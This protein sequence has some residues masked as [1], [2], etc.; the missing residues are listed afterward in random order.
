MVVLLR[1]HCVLYRGNYGFFRQ[2]LLPVNGIVQLDSMKGSSYSGLFPNLLRRQFVSSA[3]GHGIQRA[4]PRAKRDIAG[5][6]R[7]KFFLYILIDRGTGHINGDR[8][9]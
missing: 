2:H 3:V 7:P 5:R 9:F 4:D 8:I 1:A 6:F